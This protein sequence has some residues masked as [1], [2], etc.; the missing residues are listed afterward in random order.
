MKYV[1]RIIRII[2]LVILVWSVLVLIALAGVRNQ[3]DTLPK[4]FGSY[5]KLMDDN[6]MAPTAGKGALVILREEN[7]FEPGD[8]A[9]YLDDE[10]RVSIGRIK[11]IGGEVSGV[12]VTIPYEELKAQAENLSSAGASS[13]MEEDPEVVLTHDADGK[14]TLIPADRLNGKEVFHS[15]LAGDL[16]GIYENTP[17]A[18]FITILSF[19]IALWP[20]GDRRMRKPN[21]SDR[22]INGPWIG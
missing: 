5:M 19:L 9:S 4:V 17:A 3:R 7:P 14:E 6:S 2:A 18:A 12:S 15:Q 13:V 11:S 16:V 20:F 8:I 21:Y 10:N 22:D 1:I